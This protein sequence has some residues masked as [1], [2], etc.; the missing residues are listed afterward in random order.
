MDHPTIMRRLVSSPQKS[1][2]PKVLYMYVAKMEF[3]RGQSLVNSGRSSLVWTQGA[4][5]FGGAQYFYRSFVE[6]R[7]FACITFH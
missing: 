6:V 2:S 4:Q 1:N 7:P 3:R 5:G